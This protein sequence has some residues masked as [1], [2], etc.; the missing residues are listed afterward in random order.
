MVL[1]KM[2]NI[3][4]CQLGISA[5]CLTLACLG[6]AEAK[7]FRHKLQGTVQVNY[8][9]ADSQVSFLE[10]GLSPLAL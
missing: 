10:G 8:V 9:D 1:N 6:Q 7:G 2:Q 5:I 4:R 3:K